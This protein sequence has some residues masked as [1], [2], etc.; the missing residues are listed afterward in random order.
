MPR[1]RRGGW[2]SSTRR[3]DK[4]DRT[5]NAQNDDKDGR[6]RDAMGRGEA[7]GAAEGF[8]E[9]EGAS[10]GVLPCDELRR[11]PMGVLACSCIFSRRSAMSRRRVCVC[12]G[13][14]CFSVSLEARF[15]WPG[16]WMAS[17]LHPVQSPNPTSLAAPSP[18]VLPLHSRIL[19]SPL[20]YAPRHTY[21]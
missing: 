2:G 17:R 16:P 12:T 6:P 20:P 8:L 10:L 21:M 18:S 11:T 4:S 14:A 7:E 15:T 9:A 13:V 19:S 1:A 5:A 3:Q